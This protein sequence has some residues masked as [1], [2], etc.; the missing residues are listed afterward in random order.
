MKKRWI[1][2][3]IAV[4]MAVGQPVIPAVKAE[5]VSSTD[6][7]ARQDVTE[8]QVALEDV[9]SGMAAQK[10]EDTTND[11][12]EFLRD[13]TGSFDLKYKF[14]LN[15]ASYVTVEGICNMF[16]Y[17]FAGDWKLYLS[18]SEGSLDCQLGSNSARDSES[19]NAQVAL[20]SGTYWLTLRITKKEESS[21]YITDGSYVSIG[22]S[23]QEMVDR[24][25]GFKGSTDLDAIPLV[26]GEASW[27]CIT[28]V[29]KIGVMPNAVQQQVFKFDLTRKSVVNLKKV[30]SRP[31]DFSSI[32]SDTKNFLMVKAEDGSTLLNTTDH[33]ENVTEGSVE[34]EAGTYYVV[35]GY[36]RFC[37]VS[38]TASWAEQAA[39]VKKI[40][41][42]TV[43]AKAKK[44][45][46]TG[47]TQGL[48]KVSIEIGGK[49]YSKKSNNK[50]EYKVRVP[51]LKSGTVLQVTASKKG[52]KSKAK[53]VVVS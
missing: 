4:S 19:I 49:V 52:Y 42:L 38:V 17:N 33:K 7:S 2:L 14:T 8:L 41:K 24:T 1:A 5:T 47:K 11:V 31:L 32:L 6:M 26:N 37:E 9:Y 28:G 29:T 22:V 3:M 15:K 44:R 13:R 45:Y 23:A 51:K 34:L 18:T 40:K 25:G 43:K 20:E 12:V 36:P 21:S 50:G 30:V 46:V 53:I 10:F 35:V 16:T 48:A 39:S 27:G